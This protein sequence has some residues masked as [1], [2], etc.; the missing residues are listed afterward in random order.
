MM[1]TQ[2]RI[3]IRDGKRPPP[4]PRWMNRVSS[5][6][7]APAWQLRFHRWLYIRTDGRVGPGMIGAWT[8]LL[9][10]TGRRSGQTRTSA[11]V[12]ALDADR[13][14]IAASNE[15]KDTAP[16]WFH[17][18][19]ANPRVELQ[20]GRERVPGF[21]SVI[22]ASHPDYPRLWQLMN[23][24]NNR[25]YDAYQAKTSRP[26]PLVAIEPATNP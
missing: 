14:I 13:I 23:G 8:L 6:K 4:F 16:A 3:L 17:N 11:L 18:L 24:T 5:P 22:E 7:S 21:A 20:I 15:G 1:T 9:R 25:R 12:F 19:C 10:T 2:T 26:I